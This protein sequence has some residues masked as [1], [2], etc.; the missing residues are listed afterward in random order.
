MK[1]THVSGMWS[2]SSN[3]G[4]SIG[5]WVAEQGFP[6]LSLMTDY[7]AHPQGSRT[8]SGHPLWVKSYSSHS[9]KEVT[10]TR[11]STALRNTLGIHKFSE[12]KLCQL[13][14]QEALHH[15]GR[16]NK[17]SPLLKQTKKKKIVLIGKKHQSLMLTSFALSIQ[18]HPSSE[19]R[20][21]RAQLQLSLLAPT[22][23]VLLYPKHQA[24]QPTLSSLQ[25]QHY[26][27]P[28][29]LVDLPKLR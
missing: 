25:E 18:P 21:D 1:L 14:K 23:L 6:E 28:F 5:T 3:L 9:G 4:R 13:W 22:H 7:T 20:D 29:F 2:E 26:G 17:A 11:G 15:Y 19:W 16:R 24:S 12:C 10:Q 27:W 8:S